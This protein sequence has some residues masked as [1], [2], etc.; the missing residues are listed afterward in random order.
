MW[1]C[2]H[3]FNASVTTSAHSLPLPAL[4]LLCFQKPCATLTGQHNVDLQNL[5][6][7]PSLVHSCI[8][9]VMKA[10]LC[11][12]QPEVESSGVLV[13]DLANDIDDVEQRSWAG[14]AEWMKQRYHAECSAVSGLHSLAS[15][16]AFHGQPLPYQLDLQVCPH[17]NHLCCCL[18]PSHN[19][20]YQPS[21]HAFCQ[22]K[23][24]LH[25]SFASTWPDC[26]C[27]LDL[28]GCPRAAKFIIV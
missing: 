11:S 4:Q 10:V 26:P 7:V 14:L 25:S 16:A 21:C 28:Q 18:S 19:T 22:A 2:D 1:L 12:M 15:Q 23:L 17:C 24:R 20:T 27:Q 6:S 9:I 8:G 3:S 5:A 13:Q